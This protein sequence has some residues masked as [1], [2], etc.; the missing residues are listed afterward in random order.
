MMKRRIKI[1]II[2]IIIFLLIGLTIVTS[3]QAIQIA[4][5]NEEKNVIVVDINGRGDYR[6]I[7]NAINNAESGSTIFVKAGEYKEII[8]LKKPISLLGE[9]K[10]STLINPI[11]EKNKFAICLGASGIKIQNFGIKNGAPG[12]YA[13]AIRIT[14]SN[15]EIQNCNIFDT[16]VGIIIWTSNNIIDNCVFWGCEDEGIALIGTSYS[17]CKNNKIKNCI[18]RDNCDGVELQYSSKNIIS[19]CDFYDNNHTGIDAIASSNNENIITNCR[20]YNNKVNGI[21]FSSS[22]DNEVNDCLIYENDNGNIVSNGDSIN[23]Q[24]SSNGY[25]EP[26]NNKFS[27][28]EIFH[29]I[30]SRISESNN[31]GLGS[32]LR[33]LVSF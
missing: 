30:L 23:N 17:D 28:R 5:S 11:S 3:I 32:L 15:I 1:T 29:Y 26:E 7:Q 25:S 10:D 6:S 12:L 20:I 21:Y 27:L 13:S 9:D 31:R 16:P 24:I 22:S 8:T 19:N 18:F 33:A 14:S 2:S 4:N